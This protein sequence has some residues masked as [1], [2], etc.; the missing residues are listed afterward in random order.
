MEFIE[1]GLCGT[2]DKWNS[3]KEAF[4]ELLTDGIH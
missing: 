1:R 2:T 4:V 3:L